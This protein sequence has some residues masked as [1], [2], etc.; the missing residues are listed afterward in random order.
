VKAIRGFALEGEPPVEAGTELGVVAVTAKGVQ[1]RVPDRDT[2]VVVE[3]VET[4]AIA[5]ARERVLLPP[6][7]RPS[8]IAAALRGVMVDA[9]GKPAD[10]RRLDE[11]Q[12]FA[13]Y[14]GASWCPPCRKFSPE[15]VRFVNRVSKQNPRLTVV[16]MSDDKDGAE[17]LQYMKQEKMPWNAVPYAA[18]EK[19]PP[20]LS[21]IRGGIPQLAIVDRHGKL[22]AEAFDGEQYLGPTVP[23]Q[24]LSKL[25]ESGAA[26]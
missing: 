3:V 20:L 16:M 14:Y 8:R 23:L 21:Y 1:V 25:L 9:D 11:T 10:D 12:V 7:K 4:D 24:A 19:S 26:K 17:M 22:L 2:T 5:R 6:E 15:L 18:L 13:L